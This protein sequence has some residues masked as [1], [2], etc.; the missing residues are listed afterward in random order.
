MDGPDDTGTASTDESKYTMPWLHAKY[1][2]FK[3]TYQPS[4]TSVGNNFI[5]ARGF[6][7][8]SS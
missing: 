5:S 7:Y 2:Y 4:S 8:C 1:N 6:I 3:I